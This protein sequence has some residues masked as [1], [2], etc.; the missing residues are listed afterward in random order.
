MRSFASV[1]ELPADEQALVLAARRARGL[2]Y[3]PYSRFLVGAALLLDDGGVVLGANQENASYGLTVCAER[4]A[5]WNAWIAGHAGRLRGIAVTGAPASVGLEPPWPDRA[6]AAPISA[7]GAC[8]QVLA[9]ARYRLRQVAPDAS[10]FVL[11]DSLG[12]PLHRHDDTLE[13][14]PGAFEPSSLV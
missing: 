7:C 11:L 14:L 12:G 8:R 10:L 1:D 4:T 6:S 9:E 2:A 3:A 5:V 13:L